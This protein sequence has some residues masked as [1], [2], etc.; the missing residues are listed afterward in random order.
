MFLLEDI[1]VVFLKLEVDIV[2]RLVWVI[3]VNLLIGKE[4]SYFVSWND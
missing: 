2:I 4:R 3:Y 1:V